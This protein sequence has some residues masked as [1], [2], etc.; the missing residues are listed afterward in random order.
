MACAAYK[1]TKFINSYLFLLVILRLRLLPPRLANATMVAMMVMIN[2]M[3]MSPTTTTM[4]AMKQLRPH[5]TEVTT[6]KEGT[7]VLASLVI[8]SQLCFA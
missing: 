2:R 7:Y 1:L 3:S 5:L 8:S 6:S 4:I